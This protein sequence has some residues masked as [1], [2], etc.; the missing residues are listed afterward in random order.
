MVK[1]PPELIVAL[2]V[3]TFSEALSLRDQLDGVVSFFK[4]GKELF[5]A[6]GPEIVRALSPACTRP[7]AKR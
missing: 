7:G 3:P 6:V 1:T 4:V 5:T 2:D